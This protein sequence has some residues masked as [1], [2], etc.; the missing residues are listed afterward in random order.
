MTRSV[1]QS[2]SA[3]PDIAARTALA[4]LGGYAFTYAATAALARLL[5]MDRVD[6]LATAS[7]LSFVVYLGFILW[8]FT[9]TSVRRVLAGVSGA[10]PLAAIG[11]WPQLLEALQ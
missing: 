10:L 3:W 4:V 6:A 8:A 5:P 7:L 9:A 1:S 2:R 11:F